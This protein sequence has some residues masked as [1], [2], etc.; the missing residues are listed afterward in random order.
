MRS[1]CV[2]MRTLMRA[3]APSHTRS[4]A[5]SCALGTNPC[6]LLR[7]LACVHALS[8]ARSCAHPRALMR[9]LERSCI[10]SRAHVRHLS[11]AHKPTR[12]RSCIP[13][14]RSCALSRALMRPFLCA[15]SRRCPSH[16][17]RD[18]CIY[19]GGRVEEKQST[20][21]PGMPRCQRCSVSVSSLMPAPCPATIMR[22]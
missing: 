13:R 20:R 15:I 5:L 18:R 2:L 4:F 17:I 16:A 12:A 19:E 7:P 10:L 14:A 1:S 11:R 21:A 9:P 22:R 8:R 3:H 6:A